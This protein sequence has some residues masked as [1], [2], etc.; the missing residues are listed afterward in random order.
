MTDS[1]EKQRLAHLWPWMLA[2]SIVLLI[3]LLW[4]GRG[5]IRTVMRNWTGEE[6]LTEQIKGVGALVW[7]RLRHGTPET[8]P[9]VP[10]AHT[11][12]CPFGVNTFL[13][14][15]VEA[16]KVA[17]S[18]E[19]IADAGFCW[20]RQEFPWEDIEISAKGDFWDQKWDQNAWDKYDRIVDLADQYGLQVIA[21]LDNP[22]A[23]SREA[24]DEMGTRAPPDDFAGASVAFGKRAQQRRR[25]NHVTQGAK[26]DQQRCARHRNGADRR[27]TQCMY[28]CNFRDGRGV[29]DFVFIDDAV[30]SVTHGLHPKN[31]ILP[32]C[33]EL[34][35]FE[36]QTIGFWIAY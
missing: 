2:V 1:K 11:G 32:D 22:P 23:W 33:A 7:L 35:Q 25:Q 31:E 28:I 14:Q 17:R 34:F 5:R 9:Y 10:I 36:N 19:M 13:E 26:S 3:A 21:R 30:L 18:L 27:V 24:G 15:E 29:R 20:I 4:L 8:D 16:T 6:A 12:V